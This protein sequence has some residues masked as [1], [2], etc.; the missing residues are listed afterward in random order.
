M[1]FRGV[2]GE[3]RVGGRIAVTLTDWTFSATSKE[4][5]LTASIKT[6][7]DFLTRDLGPYELR[8][9]VGKQRMRYQN[10]IVTFDGLKLV[11]DGNEAP[12]FI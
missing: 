2:E 12:E 5:S 7:D 1:N 10:V 9:V 4:W 11:A 8:L 6:R 3:L